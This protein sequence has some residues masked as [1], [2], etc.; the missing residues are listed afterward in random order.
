MCVRERL[1]SRQ[2]NSRRLEH[3]LQEEV[4]RPEENMPRAN[5]HIPDHVESTRDESRVE[6]LKKK[7]VGDI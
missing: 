7:N 3:A 1:A 6:A 4:V 2:G 5:S